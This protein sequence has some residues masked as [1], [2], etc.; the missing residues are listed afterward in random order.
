[1]IAGISGLFVFANM[2]SAGVISVANPSFEDPVVSGPAWSTD[3]A[4]GW[5]TNSGQSGV[6]NPTAGGFGGAAPDGNQV[7][8]TFQNASLIQDVGAVI[9]AGETYTLTVDVGARSDGVAFGNYQLYLGYGGHDL[10]TTTIFGSV[11]T[12]VT[13]AAGTYSLVSVSGVAPAGTTGQHL[14]I[15]LDGNT[16]VTGQAGSDLF[17]KVSL[18]T[19]TVPEPGSLTILLGLA[20][21]G[22]T[23]WLKKRNKKVVSV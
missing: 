15:F 19:G 12:P 5:Q 23:P 2:V 3:T 21:F 1:V 17:D 22:G 18:T 6:L 13:P 10:A 11:D 20:C 16:I 8:W 7:G 4:T 9:T 14:L